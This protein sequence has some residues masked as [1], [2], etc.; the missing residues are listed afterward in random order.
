MQPA[1]IRLIDNLRKQLDISDWQGTYRDIQVWGDNIPDE[2]KATVLQLRQ[3]LE[4]ALPEQTTEIEEA[5]AQLPSSYPGYE[6]CLQKG[7]RQVHVDLWELCYRICFRSQAGWHDDV[8]VEI[9]M[10]LIDEAGDVEWNQLEEK[11]KQIVEQV[12]A[13]LSEEMR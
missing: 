3:Q 12:F 8:P 6:L 13:N 10:S 9:D 4:T 7:D 11:T 5:L 1:F 2:T